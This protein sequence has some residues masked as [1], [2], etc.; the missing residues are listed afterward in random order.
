MHE[1][2]NSIYLKR[3]IWGNNVIHWYLIIISRAVNYLLVIESFWRKFSVC[4][5][6]DSY[7]IWNSLKFAIRQLCSIYMLLNLYLKKQSNELCNQF[8]LLLGILYLFL[9]LIYLVFMLKELT[10]ILENLFGYDN[11][12]TLF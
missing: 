1:I 2:I 10:K 7:I 9:L 11:L 3:N 8:F 4:F 6:M 5:M 12:K